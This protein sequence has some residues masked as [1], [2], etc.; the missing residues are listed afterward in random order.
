MPHSTRDLFGLAIQYAADTEWLARVVERELPLPGYARDLLHGRL[1]LFAS[2]T[3]RPPQPPGALRPGRHIEGQLQLDGLLWLRSASGAC[4]FADAER[5]VGRIYAPENL[6]ATPSEVS[7]GCAAVLSHLLRGIGLVT[8]HAAGVRTAAGAFIICGQS[9][10]GKSTSAAILASRSGFQTIA[11]DRM[12][13]TD[14]GRVLPYPGLPSLRAP[15]K[16][17]LEANPPAAVTES[18]QVAGLLFPRVSPSEPTALT[19]LSRLEALTGLVDAALV[20]H[21]RVGEQLRALGELARTVA[22]R[23]VTLGV[24]WERMP[25]LVS[26]FWAI[27]RQSENRMA[28]LSL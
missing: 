1:H 21:G 9:G 20:P 15:A 3:Q 28:A 17:W 10:S 18:L 7:A 22:A 27:P 2:T 12:L 13:L 14:S 4:F 16:R 26:E 11:D 25:D 5:R 24:G 6:E 23:R 8:I 19:P